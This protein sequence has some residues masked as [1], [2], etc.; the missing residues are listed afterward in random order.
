MSTREWG[1][2]LLATVLLTLLWTAPWLAHVGTRIPDPS[3]GQ[4]I[5]AADARLVVWVMAWEAHALIT[6]PLSFFD[7]NIFHPSAGMLT[8]SDTFL[9]P[10]IF[11]APIYLATGNA[12]LAANLLTIATYG[13][14]FF[15]MYV[16]L[17]RTGAEPI[18]SAIAGIAVAL[19]PFRL[20]AD[21]HTLQYSSA[22]L[23]LVVLACLRV[24][25]RRTTWLAGLAILLGLFAS[26]YT[27]A[28]VLMIV[29]IEVLVGLLEG[30]RGKSGRLIAATLPGLV[31][32]GVLAIPWLARSDESGTMPANMLESFEYVG[33][34]FLPYYLDPSG[35]TV[36]FG[37]AV[38]VL[39]AIGLLRP[40]IRRE[41]PSAHWWRWV[42]FFVA[43]TL[44]AL[45]PSLEIGD[46]RVPM[47]FSV[48]IETPVRALR[49]FPRFIILAHMGAAG[50]AARG[51]TA[52]IAWC[53]SHAGGRAALGFGVIL[54]LPTLI[55]R[56]VVLLETTFD[57]VPV[58]EQAAPFYAKLAE[59]EP[60]PLLEV[61]GPWSAAA[62]NRKIVQSEFMVQ[63]TR[64]WRPL[65]NGHTGYPPWWSN[66]IRQEIYTAPEDPAALQSVV[67]AT[68]L[69]WIL[70]HRFH[71]GRVEW[72]RWL[73]AREQP[74]FETVLEGKNHLLLRVTVDPIRP[75]Q[76]LLRDAK[77]NPDETL[78]GTSRAELA[79]DAV[80]GELELVD[81]A[82]E[83]GG[84]A[85]FAVHLIAHNTGEVAWPGLAPMKDPD[86]GLV[87]IESEWIPTG[88]DTAEGQTMSR[89]VRD[90][91]PGEA[92]HN[93][94]EL[95][96]PTTPGAYDLR[97]GLRQAGGP[98]LD[99][100]APLSLPVVVK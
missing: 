80:R 68:G 86:D 24:D 93:W 34:L 38:V 32:L 83:V 96:T 52:S 92:Q 31:L 64:H 48:L 66:W 37:W 3:P 58:G 99:G 2:V 33:R 28:M 12:I 71:A 60:G 40:A 39:A 69:R 18:P 70:V 44:L 47:P 17:R 59:G 62:L 65:L 94:I 11:A 51:A 45:G 73:G 1:F 14:C 72:E 19:G 97:V 36:G 20:P 87:M 16:V 4:D 98:R 57:R 43:G 46:V 85:A 84:G 61:P 10:A 95:E 29:G 91:F 26:F 88:S 76:S 55:P 100:V 81:A 50:L 82:T 21:V 6:Q 9:T 15:L 22:L 63:S 74:G 78:L 49:A 27:A 90:L 79:V 67:D 89:L 8:G 13:L 25:S 7:A 54:V 23:A 35:P 30:D 53:R 75:W 5:N 42:L 41:A 77:T 56:S